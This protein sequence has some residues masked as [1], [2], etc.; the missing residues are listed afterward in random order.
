M[1]VNKFDFAFLIIT[2]G[3]MNVVLF[4]QVLVHQRHFDLFIDQIVIYLG[5]V[6]KGASSEL[7]SAFVNDNSTFW[8]DP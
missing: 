8:K 6:K 1:R 2:K 5:N 7:M 4:N 3:Q